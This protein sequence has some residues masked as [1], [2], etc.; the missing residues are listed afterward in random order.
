MRS[1]VWVTPTGPCGLDRHLVCIQEWLHWEMLTKLCPFVWGL[2]TRLYTKHTAHT[3][4][5]YINRLLGKP[6]FLQ[7][8]SLA[9][10]I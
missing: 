8:K 9:F 6:D 2:C 3:L 1:Q 4:C 5:R 7:I 10:P